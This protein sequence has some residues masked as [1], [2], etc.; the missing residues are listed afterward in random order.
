MDLKN[1]FSFVSIDD[2]AKKFQEKSHYLLFSMQS[3]KAI[4]ETFLTQFPIN[5]HQVGENSQLACCS[6]I[7]WSGEENVR[8]QEYSD[9]SGIGIVLH[10]NN[11]EIPQGDL[12]AKNSGNQLVKESKKSDFKDSVKGF[13]EYNSVP[14]PLNTKYANKAGYARQV[15]GKNN[16]GAFFTTNL[17]KHE[18]TGEGQSVYHEEGSV[19]LFAMNIL[20]KFIKYSQYAKVKTQKKKIHPHR[21]RQ[22]INANQE[23][24]LNEALIYQKVGQPNPIIGFIITKDLSASEKQQL[25][26]LMKEKKDFSLYFYNIKAGKNIVRLLS[27][28][29]AIDFLESQ[30]TFQQ[31]FETA[32][33]FSGYF[34]QGVRE[35]IDKVQKT[36]DVLNEALAAVILSDQHNDL[37]KL[38]DNY[39][40]K[41]DSYR[42]NDNIDYKHGFWFFSVPRGINRKANY[43]LAKEL[44]AELQEGKDISCIFD[45]KAIETNKE[46]FLKDKNLPIF[47]SKNI[48]SSGLKEIINQAK[49]FIQ[50]ENISGKL[51]K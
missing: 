20:K 42:L 46:N 9:S 37:I 33:P 23:M 40:A 34:S 41:I 22:Y 44:R 27:N 19:S 28:D 50:N 26:A 38:L 4:K 51:K 12:R 47:W 17:A 25:L 45:D 6:T 3:V 13:G 5:A 39:I 36:G 35:D 29:Q 49:I 21:G 32:I 30:S 2:A 16:S 8:V 18:V 48:N 10:P 31:A 11:V 7:V 14:K 1:E 43:R 24:C 15:N